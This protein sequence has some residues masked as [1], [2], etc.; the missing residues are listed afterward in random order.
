MQH[1]YFGRLGAN[2]RRITIACLAATRRNVGWSIVAM[3]LVMSSSGSILAQSPG[4][5]VSAPRDDFAHRLFKAYADEWGKPPVDDPNAQPSRWPPPFPPQPVK[6][7]PYPFTDWPYGGAS[8][9]GA[10]LPNS[11]SSPL[12]AALAPTSFGRWLNENHIQIY[13][14]FNGGGNISTATNVKNGNFPAAYMYRPNIGQLDQAVV[15][16]E[17][18]PDTVQK[19]HIDWGFRV[20]ALYGENYRYTTAYGFFSDQ[21]QKRDQFNG[22]DAPMV[23][24]E[25][26]IPWVAQ[27]LLIRAGRYISVPDIEAQLAPNNYMYSHS[28]TYGYDNY[29]NTG[30]IASLQLDK[31]WMVQLGVSDGTDSMPWNAGKKD[32]GVQPTATGCVRCV[33][34]RVEDAAPPATLEPTLVR[35]LL[36]ARGIHRRRRRSRRQ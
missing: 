23:Y 26:Y 16:V 2:R 19:D 30:V 32:P 10:T 28:F 4:D 1:L 27:G 9:I 3:G 35:G 36:N 24:A 31:N 6:S 20:S 25:M 5:G 12:M 21:L 17:R 22:F 33:V 15:Y 29:T 7:P 14:W 18:L 13:G 11:V 34:E 8:T